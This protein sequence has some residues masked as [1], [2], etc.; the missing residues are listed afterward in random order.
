MLSSPQA[1]EAI[2]KSAT[3]YGSALGLKS[4]EML[5]VRL[6]TLEVLPGLRRSYVVHIFK[7][8]C[9]RLL[10]RKYTYNPGCIIGS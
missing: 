8:S 9:M 6:C 1:R 3:D 10:V 2:A 5:C 4:W 7:A